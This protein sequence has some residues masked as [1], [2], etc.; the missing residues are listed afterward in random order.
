MSKKRTIKDFVESYKNMSYCELELVSEYENYFNFVVKEKIAAQF[1]VKDWLTLLKS[2]DILFRQ[3][4]F[5]EK[6]VYFKPLYDKEKHHMMIL[7]VTK[8]IPIEYSGKYREFYRNVLIAAGDE[9]M[10]SD[11]I[12][13]L[14]KL[15]DKI[16]V[17][18]SKLPDAKSNFRRIR[19][20]T[21]KIDR[22]KGNFWRDAMEKRH[23]EII[24]LTN[25]L[26]SL[27]SELE[28]PLN[29]CSAYIDNLIPV[30]ETYPNF[31]SSFRSNWLGSE[32]WISMDEASGT[33][34]PINFDSGNT[35]IG[36]LSVAGAGI[37][38]TAIGSFISSTAGAITMAFG[39]FVVAV[40]I[41]STIISI[42]VTSYLE[43]T[44]L[45]EWY[46]ETLRKLR[47][48]KPQMAEMKEELTKINSAL[49]KMIVRFIEICRHLDSN[50]PIDESKLEDRLDKESRKEVG[51][52]IVKCMNSVIGGRSE[53]MVRYRIFNAYVNE[54]LEDRERNREKLDNKDGIKY[55]REE[56]NE[57]KE[58]ATKETKEIIAE[59]SKFTYIHALAGEKGNYSARRIA[60]RE[61]KA[62]CL[63]WCSE[64]LVGE[65]D[66]KMISDLKT[67]IKELTQNL[68]PVQRGE[69]QLI[70][71]ILYSTSPEEAIKASG[72]E[73]SKVKK[74]ARRLAEIGVIPTST[75]TAIVTAAAQTA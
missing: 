36:C 7:G 67:Q 34:L 37:G 28:E 31:C 32:I 2:D 38:I 15:R 25:S 17:F 49:K 69:L 47:K 26:E 14:E 24:D 4:N 39:I 21:E 20:E 66:Q 54:G 9:F 44:D 72:L 42:A 33:F 68:T 73:F 29:L 43:A 12:D 40:G 65:T 6:S 18:A 51:R 27:C 1:E 75:A 35:L 13:N 52:E 48:Y 56:E 50:F 62:T 30:L 11:K 55:S 5:S 46:D 45:D 70:T 64:R 41:V 74:A 60:K 10:K 19:T 53:H 57:I 63:Q 8:P 59:A 16:K 58:L 22:T 3:P 23:D 71:E 61:V